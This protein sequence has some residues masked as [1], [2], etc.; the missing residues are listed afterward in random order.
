LDELS[1]NRLGATPQLSVIH[2]LLAEPSEY[3]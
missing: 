2:L 1:S 3:P